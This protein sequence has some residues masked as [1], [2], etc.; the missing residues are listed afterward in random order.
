MLSRLL[1]DVVSIENE[2]RVRR[3][4]CQNNRTL[5]PFTWTRAR[6]SLGVACCC[7]FRGGA[8]ISRMRRSRVASRLT[9]RVGAQCAKPLQVAE[10]ALSFLLGGASRRTLRSAISG[11]GE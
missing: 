9:K 11:D 5:D 7:G 6:F 2:P 4:K 8:S 10:V 3:R 1:V